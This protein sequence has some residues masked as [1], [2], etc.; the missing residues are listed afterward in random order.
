MKLGVVLQTDPPARRVVELARLAEEAGFDYVW[1][2]DSHVLW[3]EP[4]VVYSQI[5]AATERILVGPMVTNPLSRDWSVTASLFATLNEMFGNRTV[6]GI[7]R[8]DSAVRVL[9]GSPA[10]LGALADAMRVI[11]GLASGATVTYRDREIRIPWVRD[12]ALEV[13]MAAYGPKALELAGSQADGV[14]LQLADPYLV[15]WST[16][17]AREARARSARPAEGFTVVAAAPAYVGAHLAHQRDQ[18]RWFGGMVGNHVADL[19]ERYGAR[20][21]A[22]PRALTDYVASRPAYDYAHHGKAGN[23]STDFVPDE[24]VDRFCLL[25]PVEAHLERLEELAALGVDQFAVYLMHDAKEETLEAYAE[26][27]VPRF[28][29]AK[30]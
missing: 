20:S 22:V 23:R 26:R 27:V 5:L 12:G 8:G 28:A 4:F 19:V 3:E 14:I 15:E 25:G 1:T 21:G 6:C 7:G 18:V 10:T 29:G 2:F 11:K 17:L 24:V 30:R 13:L 9:G 16:R